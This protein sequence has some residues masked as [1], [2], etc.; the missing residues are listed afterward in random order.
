MTKFIKISIIIIIYLLLLMGCLKSDNRSNFVN[1]GDIETDL[2]RDF[3]EN[4]EYEREAGN[5]E[6]ILEDIEFEL[7]I[8]EPFLKRNDIKKSKYPKI[9]VC[10]TNK[11]DKTHQIYWD[12]DFSKVLWDGELIL[13]AMNGDNI[14][15]SSDIKYKS[16]NVYPA[17]N[18]ILIKSG[19]KIYSVIN[20]ETYPGI[21]INQMFE[22]R[23]D[24]DLL[25]KI[26]NYPSKDKKYSYISHTLSI[27]IDD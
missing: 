19:E 27:F 25:L 6:K 9:S 10:L 11:G 15:E 16:S 13:E 14:W 3:N 24:V 2:L 5:I 8:D 23:G 20:F 12:N 4:V 17:D 1:N 18:I 7:M 26:K 21:F 22:Y